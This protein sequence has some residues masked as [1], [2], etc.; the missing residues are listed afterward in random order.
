[1]SVLPEA[2]SKLT[3]ETQRKEEAI[4]IVANDIIV[5]NLVY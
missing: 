2:K 5:I 1:M 4:A 3:P